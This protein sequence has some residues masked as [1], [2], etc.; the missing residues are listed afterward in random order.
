MSFPRYAAYRESGVAW[1]G[2]VP[3]HW[4]VTRLRFAAQM[5]PSK[6]EVSDLP[7]DTEVSFL[8][9]ESIGEDGIDNLAHEGASPAGA[10][11]HAHGKTAGLQPGRSRRRAA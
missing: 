1:L 8:P 4:D 7:A 3:E 9:M 6:S 10:S 5:N 11:H 2:E